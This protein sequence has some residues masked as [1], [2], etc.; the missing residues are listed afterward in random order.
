MEL[1][2]IVTLL[3]YVVLIIFLI[4]L[5]CI[6]YQFQVQTK[7]HAPGHFTLHQQCQNEMQESTNMKNLKKMKTLR[8]DRKILL[9]L[10]N[11]P[12]PKTRSSIWTTGDLEEKF[13]ED[14]DGRILND[15]STQISMYYQNEAN[16]G[17]TEIMT[18]IKKDLQNKGLYLNGPEATKN[19]K[20][21]AIEEWTHSFNDK[22]AKY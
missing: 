14:T 11:L 16:G 13:S 5:S 2:A 10:S 6:I 9:N 22:K 18:S 19:L 3:V 4:V 21:S 20:N 1:T 17:I 12:K 7:V 15:P 8:S